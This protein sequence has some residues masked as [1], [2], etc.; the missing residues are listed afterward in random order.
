MTVLFIDDDKDDYEIFSDALKIVHRG[1]ICVYA[2]NGQYALKWLED[3]VPDYIFLDINMP[4]MSGKECLREIKKIPK[5]KDIPVIVHSTTSLPRE[6]RDFGNLGATDFMIK[7][8]S[9]S[10]L[11]SRLQL[12]LLK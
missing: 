11:V 8:T 7:P 1:A 6:I 10:D 3:F 5:L 12:A 4:L 9:F 2:P